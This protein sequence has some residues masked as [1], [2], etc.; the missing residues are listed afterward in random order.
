MCG[1]LKRVAYMRGVLPLGS[2]WLMSITR[3]DSRSSTR[4]V[5]PI[6]AAMISSCMVESMTSS[7]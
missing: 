5:E 3:L 2:P 7:R 4:L 1:W 6:R